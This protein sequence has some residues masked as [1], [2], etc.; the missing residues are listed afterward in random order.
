MEKDKLESLL[1]RSNGA[2]E[3]Q[4]EC[5]QDELLAAY[6]EGGLSDASHREFEAHLADC[7]WCL[8]CVGILGW[9]HE[10]GVQEQVPELL[11]AR[12]G[13]I[14]DPS[15]QAVSRWR[16]AP[17]WAVAALLVL[18][19]GSLLSNPVFRDKVPQPAASGKVDT[20]LKT[21][22]IDPVGMQP[23]QHSPGNNI[24]VKFAEGVFKWTPVN[25]S[26]FYQVRIVTT[27]GDLLWRERVHGEHWKPPGGLVFSSGE[28]YFVRIDAFLSE[29]LSVN[30]DYVAF[31]PSERR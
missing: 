27:E 4:P 25:D 23:A 30:S 13:R 24:G 15:R 31:R 7:A 8:E 9:A 12:A 20:T 3:R 17:A 26:L 11:L 29:N 6:M 5:P 16:R 19:L 10:I 18:T 14:V 1:E 21:R 22:S 2:P 28:E